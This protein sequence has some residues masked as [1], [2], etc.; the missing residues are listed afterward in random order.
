MLPGEN[1]LSNRKELATV[2]R[3]GTFFSCSDVSIKVVKNSLEKTR[4]AV[5]VGLKYSKKAVKRNRIRRQ[6]QEIFRKN[7][8]QIKKGFDIVVFPRKGK[9][10]LDSGQWEIIIK[11][12]LEKASLIK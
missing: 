5:M 4:I 7:L 2:F 8:I 6:I 3:R 10:E 1:R 12:V 9:Q 11:E